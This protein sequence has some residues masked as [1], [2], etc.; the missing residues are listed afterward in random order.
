MLSDFKITKV[1]EKVHTVVQPIHSN[2][3]FLP[4]SAGTPIELETLLASATSV[5][6]GT[7]HLPSCFPAGGYRYVSN[8]NAFLL[9]ALKQLQPNK[10]RPAG[11]SATKRQIKLNSVSPRRACEER[12]LP[13][14]RLFCREGKGYSFSQ[15]LP[16]CHVASMLGTTW[17]I[18]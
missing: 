10:R 18:Q 12:L 8:N 15:I 9:V 16:K 1:I 4:V 14:R 3:R 17:V 6:N 2:V 7:A 13:S 5:A 11:R